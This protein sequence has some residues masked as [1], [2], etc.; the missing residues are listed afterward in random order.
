[1]SFDDKNETLE[2]TWYYNHK[3]GRT[4]AKSSMINAYRQNMI[5]I[6]MKQFRH[7]LH[8][9]RMWEDKMRKKKSKRRSK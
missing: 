8:K 5:A 6:F 2:D 9:R 7:E 4:V 1:M 3:L